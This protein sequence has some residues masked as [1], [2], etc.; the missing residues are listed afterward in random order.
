MKTISVFTFSTIGVL[1]VVFLVFAYLGPLPLINATV[2]L[3]SLTIQNNQPINWAQNGS[4]AIG[5]TGYG[6]SNQTG[7]LIPSPIAST[8]KVLLALS[9]LSKKPLAINQQGPNI[10]INQTD[11]ANYN[12]DLALGESVAKVQ[13]G[14]IITEYQALQALLIASANNF[15]QILANWA[16]G[17]TNNY[18]AFANQYAKNIGMNSTT[19]SDDSGYSTKTTGNALDL[20]VLGQKAIL[21]PVIA[22]IVKQYSAII[23][24]AGMI[25]NYNTNVDPY[26][27]KQIDGIKTG[28]TTEGG[29]NYIFSSK[30]QGYEIVGSIVGAQ[31]LSTSLSEGPKILTEYEKQIKIKSLVAANQVVG[32]YTFPWGNK[33]SI[34]SPKNISLPVEPNVKYSI[35]LNLY[36]FKISQKNIGEA[37]YLAITDNH[38]SNLYPIL[39]RNTYKNPSFWWR[40][41]YNFQRLDHSI[42]DL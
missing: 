8:V 40:I 36:P 39:F 6:V 2:T 24:V 25:A 38:K 1:L 16:F 32:Y 35:K 9:V 10:V 14:E 22:S 12:A 3:N 21:N 31:N 19:V 28:N 7:S 33:I 37:G 34:Y 26:I 4:Q 17:S 30:Y 20:V 23:P 41:K 11:L 29:G 42:S 18:I 13:P 5:I 15:A 27:N